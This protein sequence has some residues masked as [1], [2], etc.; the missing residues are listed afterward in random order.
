MAK[1]RAGHF[2]CPNCNTLYHVVKAEAA[3]ATVDP[4]HERTRSVR[5]IR[6]ARD[7][8]HLPKRWDRASRVAGWRD[9][10]GFEKSFE[11]RQGADAETLRTLAKKYHSETVGPPIQ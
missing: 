2:N 11:E 5:D 1:F 8:A 7:G 4:H 3:P 9:A 6:A 10:R